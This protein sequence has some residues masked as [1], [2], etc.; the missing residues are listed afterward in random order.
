ML[1]LEYI[2]WAS[3]TSMCIHGK[4]QYTELRFR[5]IEYTH[6]VHCIIQSMCVICLTSV[7]DKLFDF[8][9]KLTVRYP[10]LVN[11]DGSLPGFDT[12]AKRGGSV[13]KESKQ[14]YAANT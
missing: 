3:Q 14:T 13:R 10:G 6:R 4:V 11:V 1:F 12:L 9:H 5:C 7:C 2:Y 8:V